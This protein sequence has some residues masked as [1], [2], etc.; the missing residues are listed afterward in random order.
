MWFRFQY[1]TTL[2]MKL[3]KSA[4]ENDRLRDENKHL[5]QKINQLQ[6]EVRASVYLC[7]PFQVGSSVTVGGTG[8][9]LSL[10]TLSSRVV[11]YNQRYGH[12]FIFVY[13][14]K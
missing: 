12:Q 13:P 5:R 7:L 10:F 3:S 9:S 8:I 14:L 11:S 2:E 1:L 6:S 4:E